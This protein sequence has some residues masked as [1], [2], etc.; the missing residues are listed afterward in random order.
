[1]GCAAAQPIGFSHQPAGPAADCA[2][3][4]RPRAELSGEFKIPLILDALLW[5][6]YP[7]KACLLYL[8]KDSF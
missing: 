8:Y 1:M 5:K 3:V 4:G 7:S 6:N 2:S